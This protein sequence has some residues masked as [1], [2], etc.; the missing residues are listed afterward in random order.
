MTRQGISLGKLLGIPILIDYSWFLIFILM[1][2]LL[3]S[4]YYP[5]AYPNWPAAQYWILGAIT[6]IMLFV[7]VLLH[8]LGHS[9]VAQRNN[10]PVS[11]ITLFVFGGVSQ[12]TREPV[13]PLADFL[14]A[15]AGLFVSLILAA[16]FA[17]LAPLA[18]AVP[19]AAALFQYLA[20]INLFLL[21]FNVIPGFPLDGGRVFRAVVWGVTQNYQRATAVAATVGRF[22]AWVFIL[23]GVWLIFF[24]SFVNG[25]WI[26]F[27]GWYLDGASAGELRQQTVH[28]LLAGHTVRQMMGS[29]YVTIDSDCTLQKL[30]DDHVF[31]AGRRFFVVQENGRMVGIMTLH[32]FRAVPHAEWPATL[33]ARAMIPMNKVDTVGPDAEVWEA[34]QK[35]DA[36]GV[37]TL[38]VMADGRIQGVLTREHVIQYLQ[39]IRE[40]R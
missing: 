17:L 9:A 11:S 16:V 14:I 5:S 6:A 3:A 30:V 27:I 35:M 4:S 37:N 7:S 23:L 39:T 22:I 21:I 24:G 13:R 20:L 28:T 15:S 25:L 29:D 8:E 18:A 38:P 31:G 1:T 19:P 36:D 33:V 12:I 10:I 26:I 34:V 2:W 40:M 32:N